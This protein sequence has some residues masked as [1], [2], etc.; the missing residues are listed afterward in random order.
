VA[1]SH[2]FI[3]DL[4]TETTGNTV[5]GEFFNSSD[6]LNSRI[7]ENSNLYLNQGYMFQNFYFKP[8]EVSNNFKIYFQSGSYVK[9]DSSFDGSSSYNVYSVATPSITNFIYLQEPLFHG[10]RFIGDHEFIGNEIA[11]PLQA[12]AG[13]TIDCDY[14]PYQPSDATF[15]ANPSCD[16]LLTSGVFHWQK[17]DAIA[18]NTFWFRS[19]ITGQPNQYF[20]F[21]PSR[22]HRAGF[23]VLACDFIGNNIL[24]S[25]TNPTSAYN[26]SGLHCMNSG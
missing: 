8:Y 22:I 9:K 11:V 1:A 24:G 6:C 19:K 15:D 21:D 25:N 10:A 18:G 3:I 4:A 16:T 23:K 20:F 14:G 7:D 13:A 26:L 12:P 17:A 5:K 2:S